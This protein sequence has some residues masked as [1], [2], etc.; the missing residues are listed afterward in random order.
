MIDGKLR[1]L[2]EGFMEGEGKIGSRRPVAAENEVA[3][4]PRDRYDELEHR[5]RL[6]VEAEKALVAAA[7]AYCNRIV[8]P[9]ARRALMRDLRAASAAVD[10]ARAFYLD[11]SLDSDEARAHMAAWRTG[12]R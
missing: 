5:H 12:G 2:L 11:E 3:D 7:Q 9:G 1:A 4:C 10:A 6:L 8:S